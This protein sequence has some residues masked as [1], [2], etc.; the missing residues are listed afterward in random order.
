MGYLKTKLS[1]Y[2]AKESKF[3]GKAQAFSDALEYVTYLKE[4]MDRVNSKY[5]PSSKERRIKIEHI[6]ASVVLKYAKGNKQALDCSEFLLTRRVNRK[7][8]NQLKTNDILIG[9]DRLN[10]ELKLLRAERQTCKTP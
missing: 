2:E 5:S 6:L 7:I 8:S 3:N 1:K 9:L 4:D 10:D